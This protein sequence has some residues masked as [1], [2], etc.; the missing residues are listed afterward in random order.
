[1]DWPRHHRHGPTG[2]W[3]APQ[4]QSSTRFGLAGRL[5]GPSASRH[6]KPKINFSLSHYLRHNTRNPNPTQRIIRTEIPSLNLRSSHGESPHVPSQLRGRKGAAFSSPAAQWWAT[7]KQKA[8]AA[9]NHPRGEFL[10]GKT[11]A[12]PYPHVGGTGLRR[13]LARHRRVV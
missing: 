8:R 1:M 4:P 7:T 13:N 9:R 2:R 12:E 11:D 10:L 5:A 6:R 3:P